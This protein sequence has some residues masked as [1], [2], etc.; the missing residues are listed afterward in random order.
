MT[1]VILDNEAVQAIL[2]P[3]HPKF[4]SVAARIEAAR[5]RAPSRIRL[6][7]H[8]PTTVQVEAGWDRT[9]ASA[10]RLNR[11]PI[12]FD[13]LDRENANEAARV[14]T[15]AHVSPADAHLGVLC[16]RLTSTG[17]RVIVLTSDP[18]DIIRASQPASITALRI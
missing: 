11:Y 9:S 7:L 1:A 13:E 3:S 18:N 14:V 8:V 16:Q 5:W 12:R 15:E 17:E 2:R 6:S 10:A 4:R